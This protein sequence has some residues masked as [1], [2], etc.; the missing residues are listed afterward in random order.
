MITTLSAQ[1]YADSC[2]GP[3][4]EFVS[5]RKL[6]RADMNSVCVQEII[7]L[8]NGETRLIRPYMYRNFSGFSAG[9][10][11]S[12]G[13]LELRIPSIDDLDVLCSIA[14]NFGNAIVSSAKYEMA[15]ARYIDSESMR[16]MPEAQYEVVQEVSCQAPRFK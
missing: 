16:I 1:V 7:T 6:R 5:K 3:N 13:W 4:G 2:L 8:N 10:S 15:Q 11:T 9:R 14:F 12:N